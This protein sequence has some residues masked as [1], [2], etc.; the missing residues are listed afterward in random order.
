MAQ[1]SYI[2]CI[3]IVIK[4]PMRIIF[5]LIS[6][7]ISSMISGQCLT[8][9]CVNGN[10]TY[11]LKSGARY[12]GD[13]LEGA[14]HGWGT[15]IFSNG[16]V[17]EGNW[18]YRYPQGQGKLRLQDGK[19]LDG[20]WTHGSL[21]TADGYRYNMPVADLQFGCLKGNCLDG[22]GIYAYLDG[23]RYQGSFARGKADG[24]GTWFYLNGDK[25]IGNFKQ[26]LFHGK[27]AFYEREERKYTGF[28]D[29]GEYIGAEE[30]SIEEGCLSGNCDD[31]EG[32]YVFE[33]RSR[34]EGSFKASLPDGSGTCLYANGE[35]Y[36]GYWAEGAFQGAG[37]L[38]L[39][40]G[41]E[42]VGRWS[43]GE[44]MGPITPVQ[45][46]VISTETPSVAK[47]ESMEP[48]TVDKARPA[49]KTYAVVIGIGAYDHM[50]VL[51]YADDDAYRFYAFL[52]SPEGGALPDKQVKLLVDE[53]ANKE[54]ILN[55]LKEMFFQS[56]PNDVVMMYF[57]GHG[58]KGS[59]LPIDFD[60]A[61]IKVDHAEI[62]AIFE[63][64]DAALKLCIA[65]ACHAGSLL[66]SKGMDEW[67]LAALYPDLAQIAAGMALFLSS[68]S[69][70]NSLESS[71][72]RQGVFSHFLIRGLKGEA[73]SNQDQLVT[74][75][76]LYQYVYTQV[77]AY[78]VK[79]QNPVIKGNYNPS[80]PIAKIRN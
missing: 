4:V 1:K 10:G 55:A 76:E 65:D 63:D 14:F 35:E 57:S 19:I 15:C 67:A 30:A 28:F 62:N 5:L 37:T 42:V 6:M 41:S 24:W 64:T 33:D 17:Y 73:D 21:V 56:E 60:G 39:Q 68:K 8:G 69:D 27:G 66:A 75:E 2:C 71:G 11:Q 59:F 25:Y 9:N 43:A 26:N 44:F 50:P 45:Q 77:R 52:K 79:R 13:F 16:D 74:I 61:D 29:M 34:Y 18:S 22:L 38:K 70:E 48:L 72:L 53:E 36:K 3:R 20:K 78:T 31:G 54:N 80:T 49:F 47:I 32:V 40:N 23:S 51:K 46:Q 58:L 7:L 12:Q